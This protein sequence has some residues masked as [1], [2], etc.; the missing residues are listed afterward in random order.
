MPGIIC[1]VY[2]TRRGSTAQIA[3]W[4]KGDL[5][6]LG[7]RAYVYRVGGA[8]PKDCNLVMVGAPVYYERPLGSVLKFL[9]ENREWVRGKRFIVFVVCTVPRALKGYAY[10]HYAG[11]LIERITNNGGQVLEA[12]LVAGWFRKPSRQAREEVETWVRNIV[13]KLR[14]CK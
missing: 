11:P 12:S 6:S 9:E 3:E 8:P 2:D 14:L 7:C 5:E 1:I 4:I 10:K 13:D